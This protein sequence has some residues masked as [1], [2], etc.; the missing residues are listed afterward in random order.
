[1][2]G[3]DQTKGKMSSR[4]IRDGERKSEERGKDIYEVIIR[5]S[6][7]KL[8]LQHKI[9]NS[10]LRWKVAIPNSG[11]SQLLFGIAKHHKTKSPEKLVRK[12]F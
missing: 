11:Y 4:V 8:S 2:E 9:V 1:M 12:K 3:K 5:W 7:Y 6:Y 10:D